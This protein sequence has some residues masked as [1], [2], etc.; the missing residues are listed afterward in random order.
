MTTLDAWAAQNHVRR[1][2]FL[3]L[4]MQGYELEALKSGVDLLQSVRGIQVEVSLK[5]VYEMAPLYPEVRQ[6]IE[7]KGFRVERE[8]LPWPDM[9]NVLFI[10]SG[11]GS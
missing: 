5:E 4:D 9:G 11:I 2:D 7:E 6:W 8:A 10:R 3:W 1:V